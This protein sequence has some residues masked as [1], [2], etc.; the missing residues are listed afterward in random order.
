MALG[1][2]FAALDEEFA[3]LALGF[4]QPHVEDFRSFDA[5]EELLAVLAGFLADL[6][7]QVM[8]GGFAQEGFAAARGAVEQEAL[9]H[10]VLEAPEQ[11]GVQ[12]RQFDAIPDALHGFCWPP[13]ACQGIGSTRVKAQSR[14]LVPPRT[15]TATR[16]WLSNRT[17]TPSLSFSLARSEE[18]T[19]TASEMPVSFPTRRRPSESNSVP[20]PPARFSRTQRRRSRQ[21]PR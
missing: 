20:G 16:C 15:S 18:R 6:E 10:G 8:G 13:M 19:T 7:S 14:R 21:R 5:E 1:G 4:A 2:L 3:Y 17:S 9:G 11:V 12:E